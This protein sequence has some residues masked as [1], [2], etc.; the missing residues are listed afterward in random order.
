M[1]QDAVIEVE[2]PAWFGCDIPPSWE[3]SDAGVFE[4]RPGKEGEPDKHDPVC[5]VLFVTGLT[6]GSAGNWG[7][8]LAFQ[9]HDGRTK[10]LAIPAARLHEDPAILARELADAGLRIIPGKERRLVAY[11][12]SYTPSNRIQSAPRLGWMERRDGGQAFIFPDRVLSAAGNEAVVYQPERYSPTIG[13]VHS[14]GTLESW[15]AHIGR[16]I[17]DNDVLLFMAC[18]GLSTPWLK[19]ANSDS[20]IIHLWGTTSRGKTTL[21]QVAASVWGC[22]VDPGGKPRIVIYPPL[23]CHRK[24]YRRTSRS[25]FRLAAL[26]G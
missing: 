5:G 23:E 7:R 8:M 21:A 13:T 9:D 26:L 12:A 11:L 19:L 4:V 2:R 17:A 18:A 3:L 1:I 10:P 20:F 14:S 22:A 16:A 15:Q 6:T 24:R 25:A